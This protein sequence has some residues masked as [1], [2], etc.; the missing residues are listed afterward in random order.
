MSGAS[1]KFTHPKTCQEEWRVKWARLKQKTYQSGSTVPESGGDFTRR[2]AFELRRDF[3]FLLRL[4]TSNKLSGPEDPRPCLLWGVVCI[5]YL[6]N[7]RKKGEFS[8][9]NPHKRR[10]F[11][12]PHF[13]YNS[14]ISVVPI[15]ARP[16]PILTLLTLLTFR[17]HS[18]YGAH[19]QWTQKASENSDVWVILGQINSVRLNKWICA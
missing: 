9:N 10:H 19:A 4:L 13:V 7:S 8:K 15:D 18:V 16:L 1:T 11:V 14:A 6:I 5:K 3:D 12:R 17:W 2:F